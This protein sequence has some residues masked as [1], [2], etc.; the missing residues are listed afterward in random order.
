MSYRPIY[1]LRSWVP[2]IMHLSYN[3]ILNNPRCI[4]AME[5]ADLINMD[6]LSAHPGAIELLEKHEDK[7]DYSE[8]SCNT[9]AIHLFEKLYKKKM[10]ILTNEIINSAVIDITYDE[11][12]KIYNGN[13]KKLSLCKIMENTNA[14]SFIE[15]YFIDLLLDVKKCDN[16]EEYIKKTRLIESLCKNKNAIH[17][18]E[19]IDPKML[20]IIKLAENEKGYK[21]FEKNEN[22]RKSLFETT[23][24]DWLTYHG[25]ES[26][27]L[28][29]KYYPE[30]IFEYDHWIALH[31]NSS[32]YAVDILLK[33]KEKLIYRLLCF[34]ENPKIIEYFKK[35]KEKIDWKNIGYNKAAIELIEEKVY[36]GDNKNKLHEIFDFDRLVRNPEIFVLDR[37]AMQEQINKKSEK[38]N[39][40]SFVEE[41]MQKVMHPDRVRRYLYEY[42]YDILDDTYVSNIE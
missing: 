31:Y 34:N 15:K 3:A 35:Y 28:V 12:L 41:L 5:E 22:L 2:N 38:I 39:S 7:I 18:L 14:I 10:F 42:E 21:I 6:D 13:K 33:N 30:K 8:L 4:H 32:D 17:I 9:E 40:V 25:E 11:F 29:M 1:K 16:M 37:V 24:S 26:L 36:E 19:Q 23:E 20:N 27:K